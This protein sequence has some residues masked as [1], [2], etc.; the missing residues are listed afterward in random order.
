MSALLFQL[1]RRVRTTK[2]VFEYIGRSGI[3]PERL[4]WRFSEVGTIQTRR[5]PQV[6][7][8]RIMH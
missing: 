4:D 1:K 8:T 2:P 6:R 3:Q 5:S 7:E